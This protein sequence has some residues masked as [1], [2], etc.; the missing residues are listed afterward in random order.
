MKCIYCNG[1][2]EVYNSRSQKRNNNVWR[3]RRCL[4]CKATF[5]TTEA[6]DLSSTLM[7]MSSD[8]YVP[9]EPQMLFTEILLALQD[10]KN[11]YRESAELLKTISAKL[12]QLPSSPVFT[13]EQISQQ[14]A[15]VLKRF[16]PR[17]YIRYASEHPSLDR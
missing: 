4:S 2:T 5:T 17:A 11:C 12:L 3:R 13:T 9:F 10:R 16:S 8:K 7:V 15:D 6:P 1:K 14:T